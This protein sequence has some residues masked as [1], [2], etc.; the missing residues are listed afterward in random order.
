MVN[1][2]E[3]RIDADRTLRRP[4]YSLA[5]LVEVDGQPFGDEFELT[6]VRVADGDWPGTT[7]E[8]EV[9]ES[10]IERVDLSE[11]RLRRPVLVNVTLRDVEVSNASWQGMIARQVE[12]I[13]CRAVGLRLSLEQVRD[14]Y[15]EDCRYDYAAIDLDRP[16]GLVVFAGC[17]FRDAVIGGDLTRCVFH[18]CDFTGTTFQA[19]VAKGADFRTSRLGGATGLLS[20]RGARITV[21]Q[22]V[23]MVLDLATAV[24]FDLSE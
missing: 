17:D 9:R 20:L 14:F 12:M 15:A 24:G 5:D 19:R 7:G 3:R 13:G 8:G 23:G 11:S 21:D 6:G 1:Q 22:A 16:K 10:L 18:D 2:R 4:A